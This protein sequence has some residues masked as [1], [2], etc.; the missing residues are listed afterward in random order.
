MRSSQQFKR[1]GEMQSDHVTI[2]RACMAAVICAP[3]VLSPGFP[4]IVSAVPDFLGFFETV[5]H[6]IEQVK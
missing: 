6:W 1:F 2:V 4:S 3:F 5:T